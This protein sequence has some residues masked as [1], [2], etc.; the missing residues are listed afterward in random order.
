MKE[1][2]LSG[3][4]YRVG[5]LDAFKQFHLSRRIAPI[6]PTL[7]PVFVKV[8]RDG[9]IGEDLLGLV[10]VITPFTEGLASMPDEAAEYVLTVCLSACQRQT[11]QTWAPVWSQAANACMF[12]DMDIAQMMQIVA[13]VVQDSLGSFISGFLTGQQA[14][15]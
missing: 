4:S 12:D 9:G 8:M 3:Q 1:F 5:K 7:I 13:H 2:E 15:P 10:E 11:G 6:I 14:K